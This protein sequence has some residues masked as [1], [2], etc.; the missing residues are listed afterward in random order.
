MIDLKDENVKLVLE[1]MH[2]HMQQKRRKR[3]G[4]EE[5]I[6]L[7]NR[8]FYILC[9]DPQ[10]GPARCAA[11][12]SQHYGCDISS[13]QVIQIFRSRRMANPD[14]REKILR[15][16]ADVA[17]QFAKALSG[18]AG[19]FENL[20]EIRRRPAAGG[21]R[22]HDSQERIAA[23]M[24]FSRYPEID[25]YGDSEE[26]CY[27][28]NT[29]GKYYFYDMIDSVSHVY[30]FEQQR[31]R[32][33]NRKTK[34]GEEKSGKTA[35][36][37][38]GAE[39]AKQTPEQVLRKIS[40]LE[41]ALQRSDRMLQELQ[42]EF[43]DQLEAYRVKELTD[44]FSLINSEKYGCILDELLIVRRGI[45]ELRKMN[46]ELPVQIRGLVIMV[47]KLA[48]FVRDNHIDPIMKINEVREVRASDIEFCHY[49]GSPFTFPD[50]RKTV[51]VLSPGW[52]YKEKEIQISRPRLREERSE[53]SQGER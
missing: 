30:G 23:V 14:D 49:E 13:D 48:Q 45:G 35:G 46:Y 31:G 39:V 22:K 9:G 11:R 4:N 44:F 6:I 42:D 41:A 37:L 24:I 2:A 15:W 34:P 43:N 7:E 36:N 10:V 16:A 5:D 33:K 51:K 17:D 53:K 28:G 32:Q 1:E 8:L 12:F 52:I 50:E 29:L 18:N 19:A 20:E 47:Q 21:S 25:L 3:A 26:L 38:S 27:L 40:R